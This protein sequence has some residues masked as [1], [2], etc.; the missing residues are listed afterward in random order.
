M[1]LMRFAVLLLSICVCQIAFGQKVDFQREILPLLSDRCFL[2]HGPDS[3]SNE[4]GLRLDSQDA[5]Q[6]ELP[7]GDGV[8]IL[9]G[10]P[11][12]SALIERVETDDVDLVMPPKDSGRKPLTQREIELLKQWVADGGEF[13]KLWSWQPLPDKIAVPE[14]ADKTLVNNEIDAFVVSHLQGLGLAPTNEA[15]KLR[16]LRRVTL[17][18]TGLPPTIEEI[19]AFEN[20]ESEGAYETV[21][22]RLLDSTAF[23]EH[24]AVAWLDSARYADSYGY[25]SDL[26]CTVWPYRDWV[27]RAFN[28]NLPY[29]QFLT[30][31][32]AGDLL[33]NATQDQ[34]IATA[35]NRLHRMTNE[36]GSIDLEWRTEYAADRVNTF[37]SAMLGLTMECA[38]CHDHK[39]DPITQRDY[40]Q[41]TSFFNNIDEFGLYNNTPWVP[42]P[43]LLL[44]DENAVKQLAESEAKEAEVLDSLQQ[45]LRELEKTSDEEVE[46]AIVGCELPDSKIHVDFEQRDEKNQFLREADSTPVAST[47]SRNESLTGLHGQGL[48]LT[49]DDALNVPAFHLKLNQPFTISCWVKLPDELKDGVIFHQQSGTDVGFSGTEFRIR[50]G[51]LFFGMIR[52]WPGNTLAVERDEAIPRNEWVHLVARYDGSLDATGMKLFVNGEPGQSVIR[53][54]IY[55][56]AFSSENIA[57]GERFRSFGLK[58]TAIDEIQIFDIAL[59]AL[60]VSAVF[61]GVGLGE[62][63]KNAGEIDRRKFWLN[64]KNESVSA[65]CKQLSEIRFSRVMQNDPLTELMVMEEM[66]SVRETYLLERGAYDAPRTADR[67]VERDVPVDLLAFPEDASRD[68]L[69]LAEWLT[70][71]RHPLTARV[72]VNRIWQ[73]FFGFGLVQSPGDFGVQGDRPENQQLLDWLAVDFIEHGWDVKRLCRQIVLSRTYRQDSRCSEE[74]RERDP[75]NRL[76]ARG[77]SF[78][79]SAEQLRDL[80]LS[81]SGLLKASSGGPPVSPYQPEG[82]WRENNT[83]SPA[84]HQSTGDDPFRRSIY[85][86]WKRT[87]PLPNMLAF[88]AAGREVCSVV[89]SATNT[90]V[91]AFVT[92]NDPQFVEAAMFLAVRFLPEGTD[93]ESPEAINAAI[94]NMFLACV[95]RRPDEVEQQILME[96]FHEQIGDVKAEA[97]D[98]NALFSNGKRE[99]DLEKWSPERRLQLAALAIVGQAILNSD[100]TLMR[101]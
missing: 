90:P 59:D 82:L 56:N 15:T 101:R 58:Q 93:V 24:M 98:P 60:E 13:E 84:Y 76:L 71:R 69:G 32:L 88:D 41:L 96:L 57:F 9:A 94:E 28:S 89:R 85:S 19:N 52:F 14:I 17:D 64:R 67:I 100:S 70:N 40:Y 35:F 4:S 87:A 42:T 72:A 95:G 30:W 68:R 49:G 16:W 46:N 73:N 91:Q 44:R 51:K 50:N 47:N 81:V 99:L 27:I 75:Q 26:L 63:L 36:G 34:K 3:N 5:L 18:L 97:T 79:L 53:N 74:L 10:D 23:G 7:S 1:Q 21:V 66:D 33:P 6:D 20:D 29:N 11:S 62:V 61:Q 80:F 55:K 43:S 37:G 86:V 38:K 65:Y 83:M 45:L 8:A 31:Q 54:R 77:P 12:Q 25:Q 92:L 78:R 39:F 2:C 22:N 48:L